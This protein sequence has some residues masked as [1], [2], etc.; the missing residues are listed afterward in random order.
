MRVNGKPIDLV[1]PIGLRSKVLEPLMLVGPEKF[2]K[3]DIRIRVRGG[4]HVAQIYAIRLAMCKALVA[5]H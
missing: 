5:Y 4:G 3:F 2:A 1:T